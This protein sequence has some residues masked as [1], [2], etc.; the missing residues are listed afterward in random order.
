MIILDSNVISELMRPRP[1]ERVIVWLDRQP[2]SSI[3]TTS[4]T[5]FEISFGLQIMPA[6]K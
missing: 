1:D 3:W 4:I 5:L 6:G 2:R